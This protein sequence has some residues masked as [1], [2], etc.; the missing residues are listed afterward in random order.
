M[1]SW[2]ILLKARKQEKIRNE[3]KRDTEESTQS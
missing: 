3:L 2:R 1:A